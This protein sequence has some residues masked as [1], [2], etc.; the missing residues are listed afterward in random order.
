MVKENEL[1]NKKWI[2]KT[3][4]KIEGKFYSLIIGGDNKEDIVSI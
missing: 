3:I 1:D 2:F 4:C